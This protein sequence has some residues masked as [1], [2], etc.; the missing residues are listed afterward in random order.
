MLNVNVSVP[1][2]ID[3]QLKNWPFKTTLWCLLWKNDSV[4]WRAFPFIPLF[5][6]IFKSAWKNFIKVLRPL[7]FL[8]FLG[9]SWDFLS[10]RQ[11]LKCIASMLKPATLLKL[12]LL[13]GCFSCFL[14]ITNG[15]KS[16]NAPYLRNLG[17][18]W[19]FF[20]KACQFFKVKL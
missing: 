6:S 12:T 1:V 8:R 11:Y 19:D 2:F 10:V 4:N 9:L 17:M 16:C 7:V 13:H 14:N 3:C 5:L 18:S 15:T 20:T